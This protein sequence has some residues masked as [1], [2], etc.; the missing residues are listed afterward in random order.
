MIHKEHTRAAV[1]AAIQQ[2]LESSSRPRR[3]FDDGDLLFVEIGLDSL[4][5]AQVV[6]SLEQQLGVDPFRKAGIT[7]R[8]FGDL[9][10]AYHA[11]LQEV[12]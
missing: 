7:I 9:V 6:V 1:Q 10:G 12:S 5:L 2:V 3:S 4:D 11:E 8:T